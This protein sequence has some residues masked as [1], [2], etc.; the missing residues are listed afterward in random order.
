MCLGVAQCVEKDYTDG[1]GA[2]D[3]KLDE[4]A[5]TPWSYENVTRTF[6]ELNTLNCTGLEGNVNDTCELGCGLCAYA[7]L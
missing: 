3:T 6:E 2:N 7:A 4:C 5:V 1:L